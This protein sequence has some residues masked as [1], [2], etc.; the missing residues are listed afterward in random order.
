MTGLIRHLTWLPEYPLTRGNGTILI[1]FASHKK[2]CLPLL[3]QLPA[4]RHFL[5]RHLHHPQQLFLWI[6]NKRIS[7]AGVSGAIRLCL[8]VQVPVSCVHLPYFSDLL[9]QSGNPFGDVRVV[10]KYSP[11]FRMRSPR[12]R[13]CCISRFDAMVTQHVSKQKTPHPLLSECSTTNH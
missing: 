13:K 4:H 8:N 6:C 10:H 9:H 5:L 1:C 11:S 2:S 7:R 3:A 12:N